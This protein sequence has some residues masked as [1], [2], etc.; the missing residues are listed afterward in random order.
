MTPSKT[1]L[2]FFALF[3]FTYG[4]AIAFLFQSSTDLTFRSDI[5]TFF[6]ITGVYFAIWIAVK[7][8]QSSKHRENLEHQHYTERLSNE[9]QRLVGLVD[10]ITDLHKR[11]IKN[12]GDVEKIVIDQRS[13][14][15]NRFHAEKSLE[16]LRTINSIFNIPSSIRSGCDEVLSSYEAFLENVQHQCLNLNSSEQLNAVYAKQAKSFFEKP[17]FKKNSTDVIKDNFKKINLLISKIIEKS[18]IVIDD[19]SSK[20]E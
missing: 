14:E 17:F 16:R 1:Y 3:S 13:V 15:L 10:I 11:M 18:N 7:L 20:Q 12:E 6:S 8:S 9:I 19:D 5:G 2:A 4:I